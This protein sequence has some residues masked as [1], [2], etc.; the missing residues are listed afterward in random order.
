MDELIVE[1]LADVAKRL[2][3]SGERVEPWDELKTRAAELIGRN[4]GRI[5]AEETL[6][7]FVRRKGWPEKFRV[8]VSQVVQI[9]QQNR[10]TVEAQAARLASVEELQVV[11]L[12]RV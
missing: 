5:E 8:M 12:A 9:A 2:E 4:M 11:S 1:T 10:W 7:Q 6:M 3:T